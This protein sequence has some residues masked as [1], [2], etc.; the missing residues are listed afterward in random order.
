M[1][2]FYDCDDVAEMYKVKK[3]TVWGWIRRGFLSAKRVGK[4]YRISAKDLQNF[5]KKNQVKH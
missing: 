4:L 1:E 5:D 2:K 3:S